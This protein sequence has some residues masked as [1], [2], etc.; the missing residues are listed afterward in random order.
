MI[1]RYYDLVNPVR[2]LLMWYVYVLQNKQRKWYIGLTRDLR[3]RILRHNLMNDCE[4]CKFNNPKGCVAAVIIRDGKLLLL[5]RNEE[6]FKGMYDLAGGYMEQN[7]LPEEALKRELKEELGIGE[8]ELTR[9][10]EFPG[11]ATWKDNKFAVIAFAYLADFKGNIR[12]NGENS[13]HVLKKIDEVDVNSIA[14]DSN[15]EI[16]KR[17]KKDFNF[18]L[19]RIRELIRQLDST[20]AVEEQSLYK[21][22]LNGFVSKKYDGDKL[23]G[24]GWIFP[25]Q[26][27]LRKQAVI[28]DMIIDETYR[29]RGLGAAILEDLIKWAKNQGVEVIEL[30]TNPK[31]I[32]A[33]ELYQK[34]GFVLHPTNHYL[35]KV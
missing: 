8:C 21:A 9:I 24:F 23:I 3:K 15:A 34:Y 14:F 28:E 27:A 32:A 1:I 26:T 29:G 10:G 25:R 18:D 22:V 13:E 6:P 19:E 20:A 30:T 33:N 17:I 5:K 2:N 31:R 35:Y 7:E 11:T 16:V 4:L 12:L